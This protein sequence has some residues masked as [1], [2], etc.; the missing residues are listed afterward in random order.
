MSE[1]NRVAHI[2]RFMLFFHWNGKD[3]FGFSKESP[4]SVS[5]QK[6]GV[7]SRDKPLLPTG[8]QSGSH[9]CSWQQGWP[10]LDHAEF[11]LALPFLKTNL[12]KGKSAGES[13]V[14]GER[15]ARSSSI[16]PCSWPILEVQ[17]AAS[18]PAAKIMPVMGN[19][20]GHRCKQI[21]DELI[22]CSLDQCMPSIGRT[23]LC[24]G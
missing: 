4:V 8:A 12:L 7:P 2:K 23:P 5:L 19:S 11:S 14:P 9:F 24:H 1:G 21:F 17:V 15:W 22:K 6:G 3:D 20:E 13:L 10:S 18:K 16:L